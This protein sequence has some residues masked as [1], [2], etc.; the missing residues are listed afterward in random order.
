MCL[1]KT[2]SKKE[3]PER[4]AVGDQTELKGE[5]ILQFHLSGGQKQ[6]HMNEMVA[7]CLLHVNRHLFA[8]TCSLNSAP[9]LSRKATY[10][11]DVTQKHFT[12]LLCVHVFKKQHSRFLFWKFQRSVKMAVVLHSKCCNVCLHRH[13]K[14]NQNTCL[15]LF[16]HLE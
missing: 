5:Q 4:G 16:F 9:I 3:R 12:N 7:P 15:I 13:A 1:V 8:N 14:I 2:N 11:K 10:M 6:L